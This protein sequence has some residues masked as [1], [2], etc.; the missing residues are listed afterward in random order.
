[1]APTILWAQMSTP[2]ILFV[3]ERLR[4]TV[5]AG[6]QGM[7]PVSWFDFMR[8]LLHSPLFLPSG[9][10]RSDAPSRPW[11]RQ[12]EKSGK[13]ASYGSPVGVARSE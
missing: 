2:T 11:P 10:P 1:M 5:P 3:S 6:V 7:V 4:S 9:R 12:S 13:Q 8:C